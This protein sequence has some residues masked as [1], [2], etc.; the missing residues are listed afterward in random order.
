MGWHESSAYKREMEEQIAH[1]AEKKTSPWFCTE[2]AVLVE[3]RNQLTRIHYEGRIWANYVIKT[4]NLISDFLAGFSEKVLYRR[5]ECRELAMEL[6]IKSLTCE[7]DE[8]FEYI[9]HL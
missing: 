7:S 2:A 5:I 3:P 1:L 9:V 4:G 8:L 6:S